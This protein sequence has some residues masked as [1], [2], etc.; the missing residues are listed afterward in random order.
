M[1]RLYQVAPKLVERRV[2][3]SGTYPDQVVPWWQGAGG[4][5]DPCEDRPESTTDTVADHR[6]T[7]RLRDGV[8]N[9]DPGNRQVR[10]PEP[11]PQRTASNGSTITTERM[12]VVSSAETGNQ[13]DRRVR[14]FRRLALMIARPARVRM[15]F[16]KPC[17][18]ARRRVLG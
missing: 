16:R 8:R 18:R 13:A 6:G 11:D 3:G 15:R 1:D 5:V 10:W 9:A 17:F 2:G 4:T 7:N 14:P 12:E